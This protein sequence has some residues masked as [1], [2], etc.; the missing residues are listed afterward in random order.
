MNIQDIKLNDSTK[1]NIFRIA[2]D[3]DS[4]VILDTSF[5]LYRFAYVHKMLSV[6]KDNVK[7]P[8]GHL[9][10]F[11]KMLTYLKKNFNNP[12][13]IMVLDGY[14]MARKQENSQYKE[15]RGEKVVDIKDTIVDL[16]KMSALLPNVYVS[17]DKDYEADDGIYCISKTLDFWFKRNNIQRD[18]YIYAQDKDLYQCVDTNIKVI[19]KWGRGKDFLTQ[20]EVVDVEAVKEA[21]NG[22]TPSNLAKFR[23]ITGDSSDNLRGYYRFPKKQASIIANECVRTGDM[24]SPIHDDFYEVHPKVGDYLHKIN[25]DFNTF[26]SNYNIMKLKVFDFSIRVPDRDRAEELLKYYEL[27]QYTK[28]LKAFGCI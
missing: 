4:V 3:H 17:Y 18:I 21:F 11:T 10:G 6:T 20:A 15:G 26:K 2:K 14:D 9:Y 12:A 13:I 27:N 22:V 1:R 8:T 19:K 25:S 16:V 24:L 5:H 7:I 23:S 28:E